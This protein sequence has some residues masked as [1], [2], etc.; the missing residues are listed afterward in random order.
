MSDKSKLPETP[1]FEELSE[2]GAK[3]R[4]G[5]EPVSRGYDLLE[6]YRRIPNHA[7]FLYTS[8]DEV[9][10]KY[11]KNHWGAL[12]GL[13]G[14]LCDIHVSL[15]QLLGGAD[16]YS[17]LEEVKSLPG[18]SEI[19]PDDLPALHLWSSNSAVRIS[20]RTFTSEASLREVLRLVFSKIKKTSGPIEEG[21]VQEV[22]DAVTEYA[23]SQTR[24]NNGQVVSGVI[25][26]GDIIQIT[27]NFYGE[28]N[29]SSEKGESEQVVKDV[30]IGGAIKQTTNA[31]KSQQRVE[32]A[33]AT[34]LE[35]TSNSE[36]QSL[37]VGNYSASG[38]WAVVGLVVVVISIAIIK[39]LA[40]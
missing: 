11:I 19:S 2:A 20:L 17:Q 23:E 34:E 16:A 39:F 12:D 28:K 18:M 24:K 1:T 15:V 32:Q 29:M 7:M 4:L 14:D 21:S 22:V 6:R 35:Q 10:E 8:E 36:K 27:Q 31:E 13:S 5:A 9:L 30:E 25:A 26:G 37:K 3:V 38:K 40:G 33:N